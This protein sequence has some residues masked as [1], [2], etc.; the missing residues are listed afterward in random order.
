MNL[1]FND[2]T[3]NHLEVLIDHISR[4]DRMVL[5][6]GWANKDGM[7]LLADSFKH[8]LSRK[9]SITVITSGKQTKRGTRGYLKAIK[10]L[11]HIVT[12]KEATFLHSKIYLFEHGKEY[13]LMI[14]SANMMESGLTSYEEL[15]VENCGLIGDT[16]HQQVVKYLA[17]MLERTNPI[18]PKLDLV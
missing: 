15:S 1:I 2:E 18:G 3:S 12:A 6:S 13:T 10:G 4:S 8:A 7:V 11:K 17:G 16:N 14:G 9:A 5:C